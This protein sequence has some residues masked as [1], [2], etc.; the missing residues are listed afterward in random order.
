MGEI[1]AVCTCGIV[2]PHDEVLS[3]ALDQAK[4]EQAGYRLLNPCAGNLQFY[5]NAEPISADKPFWFLLVNYNGS[6]LSCDFDVPKIEA[7]VV[8]RYPEV[9]ITHSVSQRICRVNI[10]HEK[11]RKG[12]KQNG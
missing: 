8:H 11:I 10:V 5:T 1:Y 7:D 9:F 4:L 6:F 2:V 3:G 12:E